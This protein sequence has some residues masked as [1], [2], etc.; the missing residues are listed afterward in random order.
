MTWWDFK[1]GRHQQTYFFIP[2]PLFGISSPKSLNRKLVTFTR[3]PS[4]KTQS[5]CGNVILGLLKDV[6]IHKRDSLLR[7]EDYLKGVF[8]RVSFVTDTDEKDLITQTN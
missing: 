2:S 7:I 5:T 8:Y 3:V 6:E 1:K 4:E